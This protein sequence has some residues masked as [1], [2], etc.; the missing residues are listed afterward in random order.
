MCPGGKTLDCVTTIAA[1]IATANKGGTTT[2]A[3]G[4]S[5]TGSSTDPATM[6][7][8]LAVAKAADVVVLALGI[9]K[10]VEHEGVDRSDITLPGMQAAFAKA[11]YKL[12]KPVVL[13]LTNGGPLAIDDLVDGAGA[14]VEAFNPAFGAPML[15]ATLFGAENRW[16]KLP[17]T[18]YP[19]VYVC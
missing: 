13:V 16:G 10:S 17:Y 3:T 6:A 5:M 15:A 11:V 1:A 2:N 19:A 9:D 14:I 7:K 12:G 4:V 8:A 18:I